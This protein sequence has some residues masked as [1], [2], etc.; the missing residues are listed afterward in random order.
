MV[1][2]TFNPCE[3]KGIIIIDVDIYGVLG[4]KIILVEA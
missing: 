4:K 3:R 2:E 1:I